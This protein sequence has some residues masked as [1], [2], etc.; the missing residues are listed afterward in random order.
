MRPSVARAPRSLN[1]MERGVEQA[2][3]GCGCI[4][5]GSTMQRKQAHQRPTVTK[6]QVFSPFSTQ[7][8]PFPSQAP[9]P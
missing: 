4:S 8:P 6:G 3:I 9:S 7:S 2:V 5:V 1:K